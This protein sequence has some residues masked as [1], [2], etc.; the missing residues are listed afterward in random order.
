MANEGVDIRNV[1]FP[2]M[3]REALAEAVAES[4][5]QSGSKR[6]RRFAWGA[7]IRAQLALQRAGRLIR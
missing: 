4:T 2:A 3:L 6:P 1:R 7:W 5:P